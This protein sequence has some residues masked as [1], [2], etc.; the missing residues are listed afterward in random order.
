MRRVGMRGMGLIGVLIAVAIVSIM[1]AI[2]MALF[3]NNSALMMRKNV[4]QDADNMVRYVEDIL[5]Q[6]DTCSYAIR[7]AGNA[8]VGDPAVTSCFGAFQN[9][10]AGVG[11]TP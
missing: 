2:L 10:P 9:A 7:T 8:P 5:A 11:C 4:N 1:A 6:P 3:G